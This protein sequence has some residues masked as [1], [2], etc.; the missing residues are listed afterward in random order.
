MFFWP[1]IYKINE[2]K[3]IFTGSGNAQYVGDDVAVIKVVDTSPDLSLLTPACLPMTSTDSD[4]GVHAGWSSP[5][6]FHYVQSQAPGYAAYYSDF[7]KLWHRS[8]DIVP[9]LDPVTPGQW[10]YFRISD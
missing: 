3:N 6:P 2:F 7:F 10:S 5:P 8:M 1:V 9:C 4:Q